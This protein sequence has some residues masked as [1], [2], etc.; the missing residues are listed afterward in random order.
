VQSFKAEEWAKVRE[1]GKMPFL[2]RHGFLGR[3]L[4]LGVITAIAISAY[5]GNP[6][7]EAFQTL[8][9]YGL[10]AFC[11]AVFTTSGAIAANANWVVHERRHAAGGE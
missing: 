2:L 1:A 9:F 5:R 6:F 4:P 7:P 10:V 3:G 8:S 11:V